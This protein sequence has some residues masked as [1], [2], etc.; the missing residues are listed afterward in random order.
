MAAVNLTDAQRANLTKLTRDAGRDANLHQRLLNETN[1]VLK[2]YNLH[3]IV[4]L[5]PDAHLTLDLHL[6]RPTTD[7]PL[8]AFFGLHIDVWGGHNDHTGHADGA[9]WH[10]DV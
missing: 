5:Q 6:R 2:E 3:E 8:T 4:T 1:A 9:G 10:V 7:R